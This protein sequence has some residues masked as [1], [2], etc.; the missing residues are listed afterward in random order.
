MRGLPNK[1]Q[2]LE[3]Y[4]K[5]INRNIEY[6]CNMLYFNNEENCISRQFYSVVKGNIICNNEN[7]V[8]FLTE[9]FEKRKKLLHQFKQL[10][11]EIYLNNKV[12]T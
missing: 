4:N 5:E 2:K 3:E 9:L 1:K 10:N 6:T 11:E 7:E 12:F 8:N